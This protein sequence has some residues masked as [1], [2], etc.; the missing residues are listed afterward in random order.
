MTFSGRARKVVCLRKPQEIL[1]NVGIHGFLLAASVLIEPKAPL[2]FLAKARIAY[3][4]RQT[5]LV[6]PV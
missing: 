3:G 2:L 4:H 5:A 1:E 6:A